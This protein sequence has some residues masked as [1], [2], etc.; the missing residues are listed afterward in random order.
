MAPEHQASDAGRGTS[1]A[2]R[3][4]SDAGRGTFV[5]HALGRSR[6]AWLADFLTYRYWTCLHEQAIYLRQP[7]DI[8]SFLTRPRMGYAETAASFGWPLLLHANP[9]LTQVVINRDPL[10]AGAAMVASYERVG[11]DCNKKKMQAIFERGARVLKK[12]SALPGTLTLSY[13][14]LETEEGCRRV[15]EHCLP[16]TWDQAWWLHMKDVH[17]EVDLVRM[18]CYYWAHQEEI[19]AFKASCRRE[20]FRVM[21][22]QTVAVN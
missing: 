21:R 12:I 20:M 13:E 14:E 16:Y 11:I 9:R 17:V 6:T 2:G 4:A 18:V 22:R 10:E 1:N 7:S 5:I 19:E 3:G 15:F 8:K